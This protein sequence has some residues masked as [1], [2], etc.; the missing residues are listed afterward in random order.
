[1][2]AF[3]LVLSLTLLSALLPALS[4]ARS[5]TFGA[6]TEDDLSELGD[7]VLDELERFVRESKHHSTKFSLAV[8]M[9]AHN[10]YIANVLLHRPLVAHRLFPLFP[11]VNSTSENST[12]PASTEHTTQTPVTVT[13]V[14]VTPVT[15]TPVTITDSAPTECPPDTTPITTTGEDECS[16]GAGSST[17]GL[18]YE[19]VIEEEVEYSISFYVDNTE[20]PDTT[21]STTN[22]SKRKHHTHTHM[23][24]LHVHS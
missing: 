12:E 8:S 1:M 23:H 4:T 5:A 11:T 7:E 15:V 10:S 24:T 9:Q 13:P 20:V 2:R 21:A 18:D 16:C 22:C 14:T 17:A 19:V 3:A 6:V